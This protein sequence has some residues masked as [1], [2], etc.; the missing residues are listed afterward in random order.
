MKKIFVCVLLL[1]GSLVAGAQSVFPHEGC[2]SFTVQGSAALNLYENAFSYRDNGVAIDLFTY[3]GALGLG[4]DFNEAFAIRTQVAYGYDAGAANSRQTSGG[5]FYPYSF[6]HVNVFLD[7]VLNLSGIGG[8][9]TAFRPRI[10]TG[11]GGAYTFG[12]TDSGHPWQVI[13]NKNKAFGFRAGAIAEYV[14]R[15]GIGFFAD[16][17]GEFYTDQYNGLQPSEEDQQAFEGYAGFP[18]DV[19]GLVSLGMVYYF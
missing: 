9:A 17:C 8:K 14:M 1:A 10:Y 6:R 15:S 13:T 3:Q 5:G 12:F 7:A 19:R 16:A 2:V 4:Y 11:V 18:F